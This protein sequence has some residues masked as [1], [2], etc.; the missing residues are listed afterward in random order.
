MDPNATTGDGGTFLNKLMQSRQGYSAGI[1]T[2]S[3]TVPTLFGNPFRTADSA[4]LMPLTVMR[5][6][7]VEAT[8]LRSDPNTGNKTPL[9]KYTS[10]NQ[11]DDSDRNAY[12]QYQQLQKVGN[13]FTTRSNCFAVWMTVGYFEVEAIGVSSAHPDGYQLGQEIGADSGEIARHRSFYIIDRSIP[14][15]FEPGKRHNTDNC[16]LLRRFIE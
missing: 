10:T 16:V 8:L 5:Q 4:D 12:F 1:Y 2:M 14:V 11:W 6:K 13:M 7:P 3:P 9:F 15:A